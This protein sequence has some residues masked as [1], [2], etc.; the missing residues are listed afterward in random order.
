MY[1]RRFTTPSERAKLEAQLEA[2]HKKEISKANSAAEE[3]KI[4]REK[5]RN[6]RKDAQIIESK[7]SLSN[8]K[9]GKIIYTDGTEEILYYTDG[10]IE[11][12]ERQ[13]GTNVSEIILPTSVIKICSS[14]FQD[15]EQ[16]RRIEI[17]ESVTT[18]DYFAFYR[19]ISLETLTIPSSVE[20]IGCNAFAFCDKLET[21]EILGDPKLDKDSFSF[22]I[23]LKNLHFPSI[24]QI[25]IAA[26]QSCMALESVVLPDT[27]KKLEMSN[28]SRCP[29]LKSITIPAA[30]E[31]IEDYCFVDCPKFDEVNLSVADGTEKISKGD[32]CWC[33]SMVW[34][35]PIE[36]RTKMGKLIFP[37]IETV[38]LIIPAS[39]TEIDDGAFEYIPNLKNI[40]YAG[41]KEDFAKI[42]IG[43]NNPKIN[44]LFG[45]AKIHYNS[46]GE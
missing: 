24:S 21:V 23:S 35:T 46:T 3:A 28:F 39:V 45:K 41:T 40:Y 43:K 37:K 14:A 30:I 9:D 29:N 8:R 19:C 38:G 10:I 20:K 42:K 4:E 34:K 44:G 18:I 22:L 26:F 36:G 1:G 16:L 6:E 5:A 25:Y 15:C 17:P 11:I 31:E 13:F 12:T 32:F 7:T 33:P 27:L 2:E